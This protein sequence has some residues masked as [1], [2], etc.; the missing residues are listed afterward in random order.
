MRVLLIAFLSLSVFT[1]SSAVRTVDL[2]DS[3][4][5]FFLGNPNGNSKVC[6]NESSFS[7]LDGLQCLN[8]AQINGPASAAACQDACCESSVCVTWTFENQAGCWTSENT[9]DSYLNNS[10]W[11]GGYRAAPSINTT[12]A[13]GSPCSVDYNDSAWRTLSLPHDY[14]VE[15]PF[16]SS[17]SP[18]KGSLPKN[19]SWYRKTW[20][21]P[22]NTPIDSLVYLEFDSVFRS[23]DIYLNGAFVMHHEEGYTGFIVWLHNATAPVTRTGLNTL[24]IFVNA[25]DPELWSYE[26]MGITRHVYIHTA[27]PIS[28]VPWSFF[29][30][31]PLL[32]QISGGANVPQSANSALLSPQVD[33]A[34]AGA[35]PVNGTVV[36]A[37]T[38]IAS[39]VLVCVSTPVPFSL[40][41]GAWVRL[42]ASL[43]CG[44]VQLWN[45]ANGGAYLYNSTATIYN[46]AT[47]TALD[48]V[49]AR[50][51]LRSAIFTAADGFTL[52]GVKVV[53]RGFSNHIGFGGC[54]GAVPDRVLEFQLTM[55]KSIGGNSYRTA[56]NPVSR[57]FLDLA[58]E[59][60]VLVWEENRFIELGVLPS[61]RRQNSEESSSTTSVQAGGDSPPLPPL[62]PAA[63]PRLLQDCQ[64]MVLRDRNHASII[65]WSLCN[66]LG[67]ESNNPMG[68]VIAAQFKQV[69]YYADLSRAVTGNI[70]QRPYLGGRLIDEFGQA[71]DVTAFSHQNENV[72][73]YR[74]LNTYKSVGMGETGSC[75]F[76]RGV[77]NGNNGFGE[78]VLQCIATDM[79]TLAIP[80]AFG[81]FSW[82]LI[83]YLGETL[84]PAVSSHYGT[85]DLAGFPKDAVGF[86][87]ALWGETCDGSDVVIGNLDWTSPVNI[88]S[89]LDVAAFTCAPNV[90]LYVNGV[91]LGV[92]ST[93]ALA[94]GGAVW[95]K[96]IFTPG[97]ITAISR[98]ASGTQLGSFTLASAGSPYTLKLW[99]ESPYQMPR[100]GSIIAADGADVALLSVSVLDEN[101]FLCPQ[102]A[103]NVTF[104]LT[105][106][107]AVYGV[108]NG[109]PFDHSPVKNTPWRLTNHGLARLIIINTGASGP[110][111]VTAVASGLRNAT[112]NLVAE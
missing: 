77:Y 52:N 63:V 95:P 55:L 3:S 96:V 29:V 12:C 81:M 22:E 17:I 7:P 30:P 80:Y 10:N 28:V 1:F 8:F 103:F 15:S 48:A 75:Y 21:L 56:H 79:F 105:G 60:G 42:T 82:T 59:Y 106:P 64:D 37:L 98:D 18:G 11:S 90:E 112:A 33:V 57:M 102:A 49:S 25:L 38:E 109:D 111:T 19:V 46:D 13:E 108:A 88:G 47:Q 27:P 40:K 107:A 97:N 94:G 31:A 20:Q 68:A 99:V 39:G 45:T 74:A 110:I 23:A 6:M 54:G 4:W 14:G 9:C 65:I 100:N 26:G 43:N 84:A 41:S 24:A 16:N 50:V 66:E 34:N 62:P 61:P 44:P 67:C 92:Q 71:M 83:D 2:F 76:D 36:F 32:G 5:R 70:V 78:R 91:S 93:E 58:D 35:V 51:G 87:R 104:T 85:F 73:D 53:L 72:P 86:Y 89:S 101:G 69:I